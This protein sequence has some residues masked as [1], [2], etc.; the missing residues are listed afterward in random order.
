MLFLSS[1]SY[2]IY[3]YASLVS[4]LNQIFWLLALVIIGILLTRIVF[5]EG[6]E[7]RVTFVR[8]VVFFLIVSVII[9]LR[10]LILGYPV[11]PTLEGLVIV[12]IVSVV[13]L[14]IW[15]KQRVRKGK[16]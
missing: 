1:R 11:L 12:G 16:D 6:G 8:W 7:H 2:L 4:A 3:I 13:V 5:I 9:L 14:Y 10:Y 15:E